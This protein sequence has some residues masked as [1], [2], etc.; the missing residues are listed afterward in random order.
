MNFGHLPHSSM[1]NCT[2]LGLDFMKDLDA[3]EFYL[4]TWII[5]E[6]WSLE[7]SVEIVTL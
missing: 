1:A 3:N 2:K 4:G 5:L 7:H 6:N